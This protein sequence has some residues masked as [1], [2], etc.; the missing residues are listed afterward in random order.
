MRASQN[1]RARFDLKGYQSRV[2]G[3]LARIALESNRRLGRT[4]MTSTP[5]NS[6][7]C[8]R[9]LED[10]HQHHKRLAKYWADFAGGF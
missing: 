3:E 10:E 5:F 1:H 7:S 2:T 9:E 4:A 8:D 6:N